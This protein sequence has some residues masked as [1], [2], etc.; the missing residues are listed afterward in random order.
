[1]RTLIRIRIY[2]IS[3]FFV[4]CTLT[5]LSQEDNKEPAIQ[6]PGSESPHSLFAGLMYGSNM[7]YMG[8][9]V[10]QNKPY[11]SGM[12]IYG[13][14]ENLF[15]SASA[16][17][18]TLFDKLISFSSFAGSYSH[19]FSSWF[20][21][22]AGLTGF[23]VNGSLTDTL[24]SNF[25]YGYVSAGFDWKI[26]Y[27]TISAGGV[28]S[29]ATSPYLNI[30]NSRYFETPSFFSGKAYFSFDPY[31]NIMFGNLTKTTTSD[32]TTTGVSPPFKPSGRPG[33]QS[34]GTVVTTYIGMMEVDFGLP[35][36]FNAG[37][38]ALEIEPGYV[39]PAYKTSS[40]NLSS[41]E[42]FTLLVSLLYR[43][44]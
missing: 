13:Y 40:D 39:L 29:S 12:L 16:S 5:S 15:L 9:D 23:I 20:D 7:V 30:K 32:G 24:F 17:H 36:T 31:V 35:V 34:S 1:M 21:I 42:G 28:F 27:T 22:S 18:L 37:N 2:V 19:T 26:L 4:A 14:K 25:I 3:I 38:L 10:S 6:S 11:Y 33:Q 43:M 44:F 41:P 8:S